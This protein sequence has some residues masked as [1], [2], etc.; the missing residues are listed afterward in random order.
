MKRILLVATILW[1]G[2]IFAFSHR[3]A[4]IS[5]QDSST[6]SDY[7]V[8]VQ[9]NVKE[10]TTSEKIQR[11]MTFNAEKL[12]RKSAHVFIYFILGLLVTLTFYVYGTRNR[13]GLASV[14][15]CVL[16][17]ASDEIHQ[18]FIPGRGA[19]VTDVLIDTCGSIAGILVALL[20]IKMLVSRMGKGQRNKKYLN[21]IK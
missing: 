5:A 14:I 18:Y 1:M 17:A 16:Y 7:V 4:Y 9:E 12:V 19:R 20:M 11:L 21:N 10:A 3:P 15:I 8:I 6:F 2:V 13:Y